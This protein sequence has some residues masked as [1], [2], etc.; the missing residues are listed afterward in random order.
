MAFPLRSQA[1]FV[2]L[3]FLATSAN[4]ILSVRVSPAFIEGCTVRPSFLARKCVQNKSPLGD[5][6]LIGSYRRM[7]TLE[8]KE[9]PRRLG[10][11][12]LAKNGAAMKHARR[13]AE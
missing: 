1:H 12:S 11:R 6:A 13:E 4:F 9:C 7:Q 3:G 2:V 10:T 8:R 5:E